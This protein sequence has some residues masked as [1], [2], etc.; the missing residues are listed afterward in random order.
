MIG[1]GVV[2]DDHARRP[3]G[4][5]VLHLALDQRAEALAQSHRRDQQ[6]VVGAAVRIA[7]Q[8][9]EHFG[10]VVEHRFVGGEQP[11]VGVDLR[12]DAVVVAGR[13]VRVAMDAVGFLADHQAQLAVHLEVHQPVDD[14]DAGCFQPGRPGDV[15]ALVEARLELDQH[16]DLLAPLG[17][18]DQQ[19]DQRR[20]G[21]DAIQRDLDRDDVRIFDRGAQERLDRGERVERMVDQEILIGDLVEHLVGFV[22]RP[23]RARRER[24]I[25]QRRP[26]QLVSACQSP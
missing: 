21:A 1:D 9:I 17:R 5:G 23:Q 22:R 13:D 4:L 24:R 16:R 20:V 3:S 12:G 10:D 11:E 2:L 6:R 8:R 18:L 7:G 19:V 14:V 25:L 26:V 15:V